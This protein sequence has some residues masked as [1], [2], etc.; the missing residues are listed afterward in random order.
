MGSTVANA[1][2]PTPRL[3]RFQ[4]G[5]GLALGFNTVGRDMLEWGFNQGFDSK[6]GLDVAT[7][8]GLMSDIWGQIGPG[9]AAQSPQLMRDLEYGGSLG[10]N[11]SPAQ[12]CDKSA[13]S[14]SSLGYQ[15]R[16]ESSSRASVPAMAGGQNAYTDVYGGP[17]TNPPT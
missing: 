9:S 5:P 10:A 14:C 1:P 12:P 8:R 15:R 6:D 16:T 7:P 3:V 17:R 2:W 4:D 11:C 13:G